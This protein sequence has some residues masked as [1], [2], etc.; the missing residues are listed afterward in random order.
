MYQK[1]FT[2][3]LQI[4]RAQHLLRT[5]L[6]QRQAHKNSSSTVQDRKKSNLLRF[7][8]H[9]FVD[10]LHTYLTVTVFEELT[11]DMRAR[12]SKAEDLDAM[13]DIHQAYIKKLELQCVLAK[14]LQPI[15]SAI[16]QLLDI[17]VALYDAEAQTVKSTN[18][19]KS[20]ISAKEKSRRRRSALMLRSARVDV[21]SD[22]DS[23]S[24]DEGA[25]PE[26]E[27]EE[28]EYDAD[29]EKFGFHGPYPDKL[30]KMSKDFE[31][32]SS[33]IVA[34]LRGVGRAGGE[35]CWEMLAERLEG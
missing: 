28:L 21:T 14:N 11:K 12:L 16:L 33:F 29:H 6:F 30:R 24:A 26:S 8:L 25:T 22:S 4:H 27:R 17:C 3:L 23:D 13:A 15:H 19:E 9:R 31:K 18:P 2:I 35:T 10:I 7:R 5:L 32:L 1:V 34:G 20:G